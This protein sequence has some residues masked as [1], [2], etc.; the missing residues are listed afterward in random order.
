MNWLISLIIGGV[1]GWVA[2]MLMKTNAQMG[3][4]GNVVVG[5]IGSMLGYWLAGM[6]GIAAGGGIMRW[7]V[8][9]AGS[10]LLIFLLQ[11]LGLFGKAGS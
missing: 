5:V 8:A 9:V 11:K 6:L 10:S 3:L 2:S 4:I 1:I 7:V